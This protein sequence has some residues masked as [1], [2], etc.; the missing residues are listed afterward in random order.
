MGVIK[1]VEHFSHILQ[2]RRF[3]VVTDSSAIKHVEQL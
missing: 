3:K 2:G 1:T